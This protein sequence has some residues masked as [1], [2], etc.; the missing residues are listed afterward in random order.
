VRF[1]P[2]LMIRLARL[3]SKKRP[4]YR[5]VVSDSAKGRGG[6]IVE[7][8]GTYEPKRKETVTN[9]DRDRAQYW[10]SKGAHPTDTVRSLLK[11][12]PS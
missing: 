8:L 1:K 2:M 6:N 11:Q 3:G 4:H 9:I 5:I 10:L 12:T 7:S